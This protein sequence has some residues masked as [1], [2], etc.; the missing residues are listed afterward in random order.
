MLAQVFIVLF[1]ILYFFS[2][3][4]TKKKCFLVVVEPLNSICRSKFHHFYAPKKQSLR[5]AFERAMIDHV[6]RDGIIRIFRH[7]QKRAALAF[8]KEE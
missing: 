5:H 4:P 7:A 8:E 1:T 6:H 2:L 3:S